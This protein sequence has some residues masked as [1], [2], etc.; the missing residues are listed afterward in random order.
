MEESVLGVRFVG[1]VPSMFMTQ[2]SHWEKSGAHFCHRFLPGAAPDE[3][4]ARL[5]LLAPVELEERELVPGPLLLLPPTTDDEAVWLLTEALD[6]A[7]PLLLPVLRLPLPD[8]LPALI[9]E[10]TEAETP[11]VFVELPAPEAERLLA[12]ALVDPAVDE[13]T[14]AAL[15]LEPPELVAPEL[16][17]PVPGPEQPP[18]AQRTTQGENRRT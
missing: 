3:L 2:I 16:V 1:A 6:E 13:E 15:L 10:P 4:L 11:P 18:A 8:E 14:L 17:V 9:V 7:A 12:E 5:P